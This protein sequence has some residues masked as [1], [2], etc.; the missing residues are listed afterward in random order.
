MK[1][2]KIN[3]IKFLSLFFTIA[4]SVFIIGCN[5]LSPTTP[6]IN[7]FSASP[8]NITAGESSTLSWQVTDAT[9]ISISPGVGDVSGTPTGSYTVS[10]TE[11]TTYTLTAT[12]GAGPTTATVT[13]SVG[14]ALVEYSLTAIAGEGGQISPEGVITVTEG[15][16]QVFTIIPDGCHIIDEVLVD[17]LSIGTIDTYTFTDVQQDHT[18]YVSFDFPSRR[19]YNADTKVEYEIIQHAIDAAL[20]GETIIV[21]P[22]TYMENI[23]FDSRNLTLRSSDP[24]DPAIVNSTI[25]DGKDNASVV[26]LVNDTSTIIGF[27]IQN[28]NASHGGGIYVDEGSPI[29]EKNNIINNNATIYGGG[30]YIYKSSPTI[31][32]NTIIGNKASTNGGGIYVDSASSPIIGGINAVDTVDFNTVCS[33]NPNQVEPDVYPYNNIYPICIFDMKF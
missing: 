31:I 23:E 3:Y 9:S 10:P 5:G 13:V 29:I 27:T 14:T 18:L 8:T 26:R 16:S 24:L 30:I 7:S 1:S 17:G 33:N 15:G 11:T 20:D 25:I 32:G 28:G 21:C 12:N 19:I 4:I 22:G 6:I 2:R